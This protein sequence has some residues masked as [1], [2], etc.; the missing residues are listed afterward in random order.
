MF[1]FYFY[2]KYKHWIKKKIHIDHE[3]LMNRFH[4][5]FIN[6]ALLILLQISNLLT[7]K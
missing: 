1:L 5:Y 6:V 2:T 7:D 3:S 4:M